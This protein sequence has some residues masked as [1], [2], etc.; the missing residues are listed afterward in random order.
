MADTFPSLLRGLRRKANLTLG[1]LS[2][3]T[4]PAIHPTQISRFERGLQPSIDDIVRLAKALD[5]DPRELAESVLA[6]VAAR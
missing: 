5:V 2:E 3:R 4:Q 6:C 1:Q